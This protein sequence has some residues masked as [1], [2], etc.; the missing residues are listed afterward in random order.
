MKIN[1]EMNGKK[2]CS[3]NFKVFHNDDFTS[4][5]F[6]INNENH[7]DYSFAHDDFTNNFVNFWYKNRTF[8]F[9]TTENIYIFDFSLLHLLQSILQLSA[10]VFPPL[11]QGV[12]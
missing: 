9:E 10:I 12:I 1:L 7:K 8:F 4:L 3:P 2:L 5:T 6:V 11:L